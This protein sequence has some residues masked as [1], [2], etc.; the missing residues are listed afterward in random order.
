MVKCTGITNHVSL[1][2]CWSIKPCLFECFEYR[3]DTGYHGSSC[4]PVTT[5]PSDLDS[6]FSLLRQLESDWLSVVGGEIVGANE[7]C[8][9]LLSGESLYFSQ[10]TRF[11]FYRYANVCMDW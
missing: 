1:V 5:L 10:V 6:D 4:V 8:G 2:S 7:G 3:C 9:T 11:S